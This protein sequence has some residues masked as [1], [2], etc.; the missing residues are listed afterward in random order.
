MSHPEIIFIQTSN[1]PYRFSQKWRILSKLILNKNT[2]KSRATTRD[3][4]SIGASQDAAD[5]AP[6]PI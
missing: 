5:L 6:A 3:S 1:N 4:D 2:K